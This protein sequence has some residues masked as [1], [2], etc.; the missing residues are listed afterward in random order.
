[1]GRVLK[2]LDVEELKYYS[3]F[4]PFPVLRTSRES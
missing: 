3:V 2:K 1:M 4:H